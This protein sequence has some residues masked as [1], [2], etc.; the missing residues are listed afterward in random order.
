[1]T[2]FALRWPAVFT[3]VLAVGFCAIAHACNV[4]VFRFALEHWRPDPYRVIV[5]HSGELD[6]TQRELIR[7]LEEQQD[8][9][10]AN[11]A[12]H[13]VD[14][15]GDAAQSEEIAADRALYEALG[16]PALPW[17]VVQYPNHLRITK[18]AWAGSL[19]R[20]IVAAAIASPLRTEMARRL[21]DGQTAVWLFLES[22]KPEQDDPA[23]ALLE[24]QLKQLEKTLQLPELTD[25][26]SDA[27]ATTLPLE[28][29]FSLLRVPR[30]VAAEHA[31]VAML[32]GSEPDLAERSDPMLFPVFG[33]GRAL[34]PLIGAG[35]TA[36]NIHDAAAFLTGA[37][38]C[39][40]K[41]QN[42]GFDLMLS[43]DWD[44][45][46]ATNGI[47]PTATE[48]RKVPSGPPEL[49]PIPSGAPPV[50][51]ITPPPPATPAEAFQTATTGTVSGAI[52]VRQTWLYFGAVIGGVILLA[53]VV[54]IG[55]SRTAPK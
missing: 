3:V 44:S 15:A 52:T 18:P 17:L 10:L 29:K 5:F 55:Q 39:E 46:L 22:G 40:V 26:P 34:L 53:I 2:K 12:V 7:P 48:T 14:L 47:A 31:L 25:S 20:E 32:I 51:A 16:K 33:R 43:V 41:E 45:V 24:E 37:Y 8:N 42:P 28:I 54:A 1:M 27:L 38:S 13:T 30:T 6:E 9:T 23:V 4:P 19:S 50:A 36:S 21:A 11:L 35:I 49:V